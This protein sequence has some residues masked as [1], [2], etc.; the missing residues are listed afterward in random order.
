M[1]KA[2]LIVAM[3]LLVTPVMAGVTITAVNE[4]I[5][6]LNGVPQATIRVGYTTDVNVRAFALDMNVDGGMVLDRIKDFN[7]GEANGAQVGGKSGYGIFPGRFR[8]YIVVTGPNWVDPNYT[9]VTAWNDQ[10]AQ[11]TG[12]DTNHV[13]VEMG[14][15]YAG[16]T[17]RP[18]LSGTL[19]RIDVNSQSQTAC[20]LTIKAN[21]TRG[22]VVGNDGNAVATNLPITLPVSF[23]VAVP[24]VVGQLR[25]DANTL[26]T[27]AQLVVKTTSGVYSDV[28]AVNVVMSQVPAANTVVPLGSDV[29]Y[30]YSLGVIQP[31]AQLLY[32]THDPDANIPV[33]WYAVAGA[34]GYDLDR[35]ADGGANWTNI[36]ANQNITIKQNSVPVGFYR[37]RVRAKSGAMNSAYLTKTVDCN[38]YLSTCY[39]S[40][41][42]DANWKLVGRPDCWCKA[43]AAQEPNGSG[44][45]CDGDSDGATEVTGVNYRIYSKDLAHLTFNWKKKAADVTNDPNIVMAGKLK[46]TGSCSDYDHKPEVTGVNYRVYSKDLAVLTAS[47]KKKSSSTAVGTQYLPGNCPR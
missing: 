8:E 47:W 39:P 37:F 29:N 11:G 18:A 35:S 17:N 9:P 33:V 32:P 19:F 20:V 15:L 36:V 4:G 42:N 22:N 34:T 44:Y 24:N 3:L 41:S 14:T 23:T 16:D 13:I 30:V 12:L 21:A 38:A 10:T 7:T 26:I 45:Q 40:D 2:L 43:S 27:G 46:I 1:R 5:T 28:C 31:P 25:A 6:T